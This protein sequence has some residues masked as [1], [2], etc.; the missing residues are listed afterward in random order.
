M[1]MDPKKFRRL[2]IAIAIGLV[3]W[4]CP[5]PDAIKPIAWHLFAVFAA[6]IAGFILQPFPIGAVAFI[7][8]TV[9]ALTE[10]V[11]VK[12]A[13][14][15]YGNST[16]W[17]IICAFLLARAFIKSGL[18]RRI[19]Y[20]I[21]KAIGKS[22][23]TL[24]YAITLSDFVISPA[25]PSSTAR[26]GGILYPIIRSLSSALGSEPNDG[27]GRK[28]GAYIMQIEYQANA[29]TCAMFMTA[30]AGNPMAVELAAKTIG[31]EI[32]WSAW[33]LAA[34]VPG[35]ISLIVMPY[36]LYKLYTP[37]I[38][39]MPTAK[40]MAIEEL[41]KMGPM[42]RMEKIVAFVFVGSLALW[43]T[44]SI[45][46]MNATGVGMLAV[47]I[48][49]LTNVL[50]WKD[51]LKEEGAWNTMFWMG[52][53]IALAGA[54][55]SSGFIKTVAGMA[56]AAIQSAG[57]SWL[58]AF[59]ILVVIYVYSHYA[60]ASVSAHIGAMYAAF[61]AVSVAVGTPP[62]LAAIAF[63]AL[64]N[65]MIPLTHYGGGAAP[66]LY[67]A[68]YVPQGTWW[69]LGFIMVTVNLVIWLGIG[70]FWWHVIGLW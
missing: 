26:A 64:S 30:M 41:N 16:I 28:F 23:L 22:S 44:S 66:I 34:I 27:T 48:L 21:I 52:S 14:S 55:S 3:I 7:G 20:L 65:I 31:V 69:K 2:L 67:G 57:L 59:M 15:G 42:T 24:G 19:A 10:V 61:L 51:V 25:T 1:N 13:I 12:V 8:V 9:A 39:E 40:A 53:L 62:L 37:E 45:T 47:A 6:T 68:G 32:T 17:L 49:I 58:A 46:H 35:A 50:T 11:S 63:A 38:H 36:L 56:G 43:A 18:G 4:F 54:L 5:H 29:I 33:A 70:S 60:F